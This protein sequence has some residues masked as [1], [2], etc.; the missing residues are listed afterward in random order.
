M[1][2]VTLV[3][4]CLALFAAGCGDNQGPEYKYAFD[5]RLVG[6]W[7]F[8]MVD[9]YTGI[10]E[11]GGIQILETGEIRG[12]TVKWETGVLTESWRRPDWET[13]G[14]AVLSAYKGRAVI[15]VPPLGWGI[16]L[17]TRDVEVN[18]TVKND[19]LEFDQIIA[20]L[21]NR[22]ERSAVGTKIAEPVHSLFE[23][24][25]DGGS[26]K[27]VVFENDTYRDS[28]G[29]QAWGRQTSGGE[30]LLVIAAYR[31]SE[32]FMVEI[33]GFSGPGTYDVGPWVYPP[34]P[35]ACLVYYSEGGSGCVIPIHLWTASEGN[36]GSLT[37]GSYDSVTGRCT[38]TIEASLV[39]D[40]DEIERVL[41]S[42]R[43]DVP[44]YVPD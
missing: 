42:G 32:H 4:A 36:S 44:V 43:F 37:I 12:L 24:T 6:D 1:Y 2:R 31:G 38:G 16:P 26:Y 15:R 9:P 18:Y 34:V 14:Y 23:A 29:A 8:S 3:C 39:E 28:P 25:I 33:P 13:N 7:M 19:V 27:N 35:G 17:P 21:R 41:V 11:A 30:N 10:P 22:Y 40:A 20:G 5:N